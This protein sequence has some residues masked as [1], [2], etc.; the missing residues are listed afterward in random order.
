[1]SH[2]YHGRTSSLVHSVSYINLGTNNNN[3]IIICLR[4]NSRKKNVYASLF[5]IMT[6]IWPEFKSHNTTLCTYYLQLNICPDMFPE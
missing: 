6:L 1:V 5:S 4:A 2:D 3:N